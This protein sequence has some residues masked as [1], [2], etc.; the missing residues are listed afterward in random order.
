MDNS[1]GDYKYG[2]I[3]VQLDGTIERAER[4]AVQVDI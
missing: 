1:L 3:K 2:N 4:Y